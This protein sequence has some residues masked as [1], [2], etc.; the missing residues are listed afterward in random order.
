MNI[1]K[2]VPLR[3]YTSFGVGGNAE[4]L[5]EV[6]TTDELIDLLSSTDLLPIT[7]LGFGSNTLI[8]DNDIPGLVIC[9]KGGNITFSDT[10]VTIDAGVWWDD[11]VVASIEKGLWGI[12]LM[13]EIPGSVGAA[14]YINITAYGQT[15]GP[16]IEWI[17]VWDSKT[18][19][20]KRIDR[21]NLTWSYKKSIF[22]SKE[23]SHLV[24]LRVCLQLSKTMKEEL[25]YQKALDVAEKLEL[26]TNTLDNRR[27]VIIEA[28]KLAGSLWHPND[29]DI[30]KTAGSFFR[31]PVV[32]EEL[33]EQIMSYDESGKTSDQIK[34]MNKVHGGDTKRVSAAH[35]ML[36]CGFKR[37]QRWG[38]VKLNDQNL[39]K[40]EA[41]PG[42]TA[43]EIFD[44]AMLIQKSCQEKLGILLE[45]EARIIGAFS[46][47]K[48]N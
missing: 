39:L 38:N 23:N 3:D 36:A 33:A 20:L 27:M 18:E 35:V 28:R 47:S 10:N 26:T 7:L 14:T 43:Q 32:K 46:Q 21:N 34:L 24:I 48:T 31:N 17:D 44:T 15:I 12:E 5:A 13:S 37:G 41:L 42:A 8:S 40:I 19:R 4:N 6:T 11:V 2:N 16:L 9:I 22:Q 29:G 45:P 30:A 25:V 1:R